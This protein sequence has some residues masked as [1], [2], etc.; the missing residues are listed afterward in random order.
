[1]QFSKHVRGRAL[2]P[3]S[4]GGDGG[5]LYPPPP[6][7]MDLRYGDKV[8]LGPAKADYGLLVNQILDLLCSVTSVNTGQALPTPVNCTRV[9]TLFPKPASS[10]SSP[11][12]SHS[13][14]SSSYKRIWCTVAQQ[15]INFLQNLTHLDVSEN[16]IESLD[17]SALEKLENL[18]CSK[19]Q[20]LE[21]TLNGT[22]LLSVIAGNNRKL[23]NPLTC[24]NEE[25]VVILESHSIP[26]Y[27]TLLDLM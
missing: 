13:K 23:N 12:C 17:L 19:N 3:L 26:Y 11:G 18:Q 25:I 20:L 15:W 14:S 2:D 7:E 9:R 6:V 22:V 8:F 1:M 4:A 16:N 21:L 10:T 24:N 5:I 27:P